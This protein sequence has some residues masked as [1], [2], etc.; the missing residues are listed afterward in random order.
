MSK[1]RKI[2]IFTAS[3]F[4]Q[5]IAFE[6]FLYKSFPITPIP[7]YTCG[8]KI[9]NELGL[10]GQKFYQGRQWPEIVGYRSYKG[11][12]TPSAW[13]PD[14][15]ID[16]AV[17][18]LPAHLLFESFRL[19]DPNSGRPARLSEMFFLPPTDDLT[20]LSK[21]DEEMCNEE[22]LAD[23][24]QY[25]IKLYTALTFDQ[26]RCVGMYLNLLLKHQPDWP[27]GKALALFEKNRKIWINAE[28][29]P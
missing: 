27:T 28:P 8:D 26:R 3:L 1:M 5:H 2:D 15:P 25:R 16:V 6:R 13:L 19:D 21:I 7:N 14:L 17:Y 29:L 18:Y 23:Q 22:S 24:G 11:L 10:E 12:D 4:S 9:V 20:V